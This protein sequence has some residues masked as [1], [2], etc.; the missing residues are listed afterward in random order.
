[1][2]EWKA[3][4][5]A[6][7][8]PFVMTTA[9]EAVVAFATTA[10][11]AELPEAPLLRSDGSLWHAALAIADGTVMVGGVGSPEEARPAFIHLYVPDCDETYRRALE[12]GAEALM[13]P[14]DQ[15]Y[16]ER[17]GGVF[18]PAGNIWWFAT[19]KET[20]SREDLEARAQAF[21]AEQKAA[22]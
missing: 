12:A 14:K 11:D 17:A 2:A 16:G 7:V 3:P 19:F 9:P 1:M 10:L 20:L 6:T 5:V 15:F 8:S 13:A 4:G 18:D 21:E 22:G